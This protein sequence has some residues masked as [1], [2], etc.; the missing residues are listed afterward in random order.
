MKEERLDGTQKI[1]A[2]PMQYVRI[3]SWAKGL[4]EAQDGPPRGNKDKETSDTEW[5]NWPSD[6]ESSWHCDGWY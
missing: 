4:R 5:E 6:R 2:R 1:A 3:K